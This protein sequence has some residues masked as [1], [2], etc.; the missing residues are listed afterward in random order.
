MRIVIDARESGTSTGRYVDKL[1]EYLHGLKPPHEITV[2]TK[3]DRLDA[4]RTLAPTFE[5]VASD[6]KEFTFAE[7][8][9]F[10]RQIKS[11]K[12]DLIHFAMTQ[13]PVM[14]RG[15]VV[16]TIHDLTTARFP[17]PAKN[18]LVFAIKQ[19]VYRWVIKKVAK[20]SQMLITASKYVKDDVA[21]YANVSPD[22]IIVTYEAADKIAANAEPLPQLVNKEFIL[23]VGRATPH[24]N[25]QTAVE[26]FAVA[27]KSRSGLRFAVAGKLSDNHQQLKDYA[28]S[29]GIN[30]LTFTD[31]VSEGQ[32][33]WLYENA[34]AYIFPSLS[35]GFGLPGLE[36]MVHGLPVIAADATCLPEIYRAGALYFDPRSADDLAAKIGQL[37]VDP[38]LASDLRVK[39]AAVAASYSWQKMAEQTLQVYDTVLNMK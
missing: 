9:G 33:R 32:L 10:L 23:Y 16:T 17:N 34:K 22:K 21:Q 7:Q 5:I 39:G 3:S 27:Q 37:L 18:R 35:E 36:A 1:I 11:I 24:K 20:K 30:G 28:Q 19:R 14:Y 38:Q 2:L 31:M 8:L 4:L 26:A 25:L 13:Q 12:P 15:R 6:Y 29:R